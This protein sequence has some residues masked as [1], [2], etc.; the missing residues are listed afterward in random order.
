MVL[1]PELMQ[2]Y[3]ALFDRYTSTVPRFE[4][5]TL[6]RFIEGGYFSRH[7]N[8]VKGIY[9][10]RCEELLKI[11]KKYNFEISGEKAGLHLLIKTPLADKLLSCA[12]DESIRLYNLDDYYFTAPVTPSDTLIIGY[13]GSSSDELKILD[14]FLEN[15]FNLHGKQ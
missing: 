3:E 12:K 1:P 15:F 13:A 7:L 11:L 10:T 6:N 8:R 2:K 5:H 14:K 4:Q 9:K